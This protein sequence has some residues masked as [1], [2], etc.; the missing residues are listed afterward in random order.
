MSMDA[1]AAVN[2]AQTQNNGPLHQL[3][4][5]AINSFPFAELLDRTVQASFADLVQLS[6]TLPAASNIDRK[7]Q[8]LEFC[9]AKRKLF[10]KLLVLLRTSS[11]S[12]DVVRAQKIHAFV[13]TQDFAFSRA[14][15]DLF[16]IHGQMRL[17]KVAG[18]DIRT[19]VDVLT[20]GSYQRLPKVLKV[21]IF[22]QK[23][24]ETVS[25]LEDMMRIKLV[26]DEVIPAPFRQNM[27][28]AREYF[29]LEI[30]LGYREIHI[31]PRAVGD[32]VADIS[33][34]QPV[35]ESLSEAVA[36]SDDAHGRLK[37][38]LF[39]ILGT[40][41]R[42]ITIPSNITLDPTALD[43]ERLLLDLTDLL[44][45]TIIEQIRDQIVKP[46]NTTSGSGHHIFTEEHVNLKV[47]ENYINT[48]IV[49]A[50]SAI[51]YLR[52]VATIKQVETISSYIGFEVADFALMGLESPLKNIKTDE[53]Q[54][55]HLRFPG[56]ENNYLAIAAGSRADL[57]DCERRLHGEVVGPRVGPNLDNT[58]FRVWLLGPKPGIMHS[59]REIIFSFTPI[60]VSDVPGVL[61]TSSQS[62]AIQIDDSNQDVPTSPSKRAKVA[63]PSK[64]WRKMDLEYLSSIQLMSGNLFMFEK[65]VGLLESARLTFQYAIRGMN[66]PLAPN[67][68]QMTMSQLAARYP[69]IV[70]PLR[71]LLEPEIQNLAIPSK[72]GLDPNMLDLRSPASNSHGLGDIFVYL[73][74][75]KVTDSSDGQ[76]GSSLTK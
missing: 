11:K 70:L 48:D 31:P 38:S 5:A 17:A 16:A 59:R 40:R 63:V 27:K 36:L 10:T 51:L 50:K 3:P 49:K 64:I 56:E 69:K 53:V 60:T 46:D 47:V 30:S 18:Y 4:D 73:E 55:V 22:L 42:Q 72:G 67:Q 76:D 14:A 35:L 19:A 6:E 52:R 58:E 8:L 68:I 71:E 21:S 54:L 61:P 20:T 41:R 9:F 33:I 2:G 28:I 34:H 7:K 75:V 26:C 24:A 25:R 66:G 74:Q 45:R 62:V 23:T 57:L 1:A 39:G 43:I 65:L 13:D 44:S 32:P 15:D 37:I 29:E 12:K